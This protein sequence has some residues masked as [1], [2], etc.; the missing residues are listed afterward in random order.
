MSGR[1]SPRIVSQRGLLEIGS[2]RGLAGGDR[3]VCLIGRQIGWPTS[4][5]I[6][7]ENVNWSLG[8]PALILVVDRRVV[9]RV[10]PESCLR[11]P[12]EPRIKNM[13]AKN[14]AYAKENAL[15]LTYGHRIYNQPKN[16]C[17]NNGPNRTMCTQSLDPCGIAPRD[18]SAAVSTPIPVL[19]AVD[20]GK[21]M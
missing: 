16:V 8:T 1:A 6:I 15:C 18:M 12:V 4:C 14:F 9:E 21:T 3:F 19:R 11:R 7:G 17:I 20:G 5:P 2:L 13:N 10:R